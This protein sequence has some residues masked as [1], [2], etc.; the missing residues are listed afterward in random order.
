MHADAKPVEV[1]VNKELQSMSS[2][3]STRHIEVALPP[4]ASYQ[5]GDHLAVY[6]ENPSDAVEAVV[7][8]CGLRRND[9][10]VLHERRETPQVA[11]A[12]LPT[13]VPIRVE[14]LLS[15]LVDLVGPVTRRELRILAAL[16]T[17]PPEQR[18]LAALTEE[19]AFQR[20]VSGPCLSFAAL[21][22]Q[23]PS[24]PWDLE[25]VLTLRP[26]LKPRL[27]S[28][29]SSPHALPTS[30]SITVGQHTFPNSCDET[31][32]G[33]CSSYLTHCPPSAQL[34]V[35]VQDTGTTFRLPQD[36][37]QDVIMIGAGTGLA[38]M[39]GF[40]QERQAQR[41]QGQQVGQ[42]HLF[43]GCRHPEHDYIYQDE[44]AQWAD[45]GTLAGL[46]TAFSRLPDAPKVYVQ[47]R[48][49][50]QGESLWPLLSHGAYI[51]VCGDAKHMA[52]GVVKAFEEIA[53]THGG[54]SPEDARAAVQT[55]KEEGRY[56]EDVWAN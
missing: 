51:Y 30:C 55:M 39:R 45:D 37:S 13:G 21:L 32:R 29:S 11:S 7:G 41:A 35:R 31:K 44:L 16:A 10:V 53:A 23:F 19:M 12:R 4:E 52:P 36:A 25:L 54:M 49:Q 26:L 40:L 42:T 28:I 5:A 46:H 1:L 27:Y 3:R 22:E 43:F 24:V 38:P 8:G 34:R 2:D 15:H 18:R 14:E 20:D 33:L 47:Q 56:L 50:E 48:L 6:P 9:V 17:C